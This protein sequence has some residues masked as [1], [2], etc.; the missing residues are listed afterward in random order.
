MGCGPRPGCLHLA[1]VRRTGGDRGRP[2]R[3]PGP[4]HPGGPG[5]RRPPPRQGR[6]AAEHRHPRH[7]RR[8]RHLHRLHR[9]RPGGRR[10]RHRAPHG[11]ALLPVLTEDT[12][13]ARAEALI[14]TT[15]EHGLP[16]ANRHQPINRVWLTPQIHLERY[17]GG[18]V[19]A[20]GRGG[21]VRRDRGD[22]PSRLD[23]PADHGGAV[24]H[25][26]RGAV[27]GYRDRGRDGGH[28]P[29][30]LPPAQPARQEGSRR[31]GDGRGAGVVRRS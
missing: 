17:A 29:E 27:Q 10:P 26:V 13:T 30:R 9:R 3:A 24:R 28:G 4:G 7:S 14:I 6:P 22:R 23:A 5:R 25:A 11:P 19:S 1:D 21:E 20:L 8:P 16:G 18:G 2:A 12:R 31:D 15:A